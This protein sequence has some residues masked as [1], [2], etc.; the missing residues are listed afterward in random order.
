M[1][2]L[3]SACLT[4]VQCGYDGSS[5]GAPF[6][7]LERLLDLPNVV[8][9]RFCPEDVAFGTPRPIPDIEGGNGDDVLD[10]RARVVNEHGDDVTGAMLA[11]AHQMLELAQHERVHLAILMD[12]SAA[13]GSQVIYLG[14][15]SQ[16]VYQAGRGVAAALIVR[17]GI[18]VVSQRDFKTLSRI[19]AH[20]DPTFRVDP[21][22]RDH[23]ETPWYVETFGRPSGS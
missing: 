5:Y 18:A 6:T 12:I 21:G 9:V 13:C 10:G 4:G 14:R 7:H 8:S 15:R 16:R 23:H 22:A 17:A 11:A 19:V 3:M 20:L 2:V 1:R